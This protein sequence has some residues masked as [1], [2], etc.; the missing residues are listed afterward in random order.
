MPFKKSAILACIGVL[1]ATVVTAQ[2]PASDPA[3]TD[4]AMT[5]PAMTER[6]MMGSSG[7]ASPENREAMVSADDL[8]G[9]NIYSINEG[10][11]ESSWNQTRSYGAVEAGWE[12][13]GEIDDI[14]MSRDGRMVGLAVET[15][16]W[17][18]IGDD[19]VV[20][21]LEDVR[22]VSENATHSVVTR[23][24]QEQLEAK[25]ELDDSWWTD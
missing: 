11:D 6:G 8:I 15:G 3:T 16:G 23:M 9:A 25:P 7:V 14:L 20:V 24:S 17:L 2:A 13:I 22:I 4:P 12:D 21:S 5:D 10:Y 1:S 19:T 18:D